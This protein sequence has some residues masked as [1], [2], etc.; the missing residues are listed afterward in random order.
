MPLHAGDS[1]K[2]VFLTVEDYY[3]N[4]KDILLTHIYQLTNGYGSVPVQGF[5]SNMTKAFDIIKAFCDANN[6]Q[7]NVFEVNSMT[8]DNMTSL[9]L[10][11]KEVKELYIDSKLAWKKSNPLTRFKVGGNWIEVDIVGELG[12]EQIPT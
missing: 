7:L 10:N 6:E 9:S 1:G 3:G 2:P 4:R 8:T 11:G 5:G 12:T